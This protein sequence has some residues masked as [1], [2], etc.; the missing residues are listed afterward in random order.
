MLKT[1]VECVRQGA[2]TPDFVFLSFG[3]ALL[4]LSDRVN[5]PRIRRA[6]KFVGGGGIMNFLL[7]FMLLLVR[8]YIFE[9]LKHSTIPAGKMSA[10]V[11]R[12]Q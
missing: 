4:A 12:P 1:V 6:M 10:D 2:L 5:Y 11:R 7:K 3:S 9:Q 8:S